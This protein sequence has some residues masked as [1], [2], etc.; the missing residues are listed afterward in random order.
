MVTVRKNLLSKTEIGYIEEYLVAFHQRG[1]D[2]FH[3]PVHTCVLQE[4]LG[5]KLEQTAATLLPVGSSSGYTE[6]FNIPARGFTTFLMP[7]NE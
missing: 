3:R 2:K 1:A 7:K 6:Q 4:E 5:G